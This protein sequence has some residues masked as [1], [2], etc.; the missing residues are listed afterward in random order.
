MSISLILL[1]Y[2]S[3]EISYTVTPCWTLGMR[4]WKRERISF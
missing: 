2:L 3:H 4:F 1:Q